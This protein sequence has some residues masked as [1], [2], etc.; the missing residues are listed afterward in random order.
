MKEISNDWA[1]STKAL[2]QQLAK[3]K[4]E[5][6]KILVQDEFIEYFSDPEQ[7]YGGTDCEAYKGLAKVFKAQIYRLHTAGFWNRELAHNLS[8]R[9]CRMEGCATVGYEK[10]SDEDL[11][12]LNYEEIVTIY[13]AEVI[14]ERWGGAFRALFKDPFF[15]KSLKRLKELL[16]QYDNVILQEFF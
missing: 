3:S 8:I 9:F 1:R 14:H 2:N 7:N 16:S 13:M 11:N 6:Y 5:M 4:R 12:S 10:I 15:L